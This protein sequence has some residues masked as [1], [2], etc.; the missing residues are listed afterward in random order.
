[1]NDVETCVRCGVAVEVEAPAFLEWNA[2]FA[3]QATCP[4][5]GDRPED[6]ERRELG[7]RT[8]ATHRR[9]A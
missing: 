2:T 3:G 6:T 9:A 8:D 4:G 1:V 7:G 5:C